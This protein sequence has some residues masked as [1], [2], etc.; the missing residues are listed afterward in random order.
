MLIS[1]S[2]IVC[3]TCNSCTS[4]LTTLF[5]ITNFSQ[6][7]NAYNSLRTPYTTKLC[8]FER[9]VK[10]TKKSCKIMLKDDGI[11]RDIEKYLNLSG[12]R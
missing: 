10:K 8:I 3:F 1:N 6:I 7:A 2:S 5:Y 12:K 11:L 9:R 4:K